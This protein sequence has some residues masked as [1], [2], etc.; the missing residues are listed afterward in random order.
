MTQGAVHVGIELGG[1]KIVVGASDHGTELVHREVIATGDPN[2]TLTSVTES[3]QRVM[4]RHLVRA[5]GIASF[6][7]IDLRPESE[8]YG[9]MLSTPKPGWSGVDILTEIAVD[10]VPTI[11]DTDVNAAM[12]AEH[13]WGP[14]TSENAAYLTVG[15]GIGGAIWSNGGVLRGANHSEIGHLRVPRHPDDDFPGSC[16]FHGNC[17]EGMAS[18]T[19]IE[20][21]W[22]EA[23]DVLTTAATEALAFESWYVAHAIASLC[24]VI[25][26]DQVIIGG[27][28]AKMPGFHAAVSGMLLQASGGYPAIPFATD[29]PEILPPGLRDDAGVIGAIELAR[30]FPKGTNG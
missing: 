9:R 28:V 17:L 22:G 20:E 6:G 12:L 16:P 3:L 10:G 26:L 30:T 8:T 29:G 18:G 13:T 4:H 24:A 15:T 19:A 25:P 5:I 23:A 7:P 14:A 2:V 21:R 11:I 27:G 1:T